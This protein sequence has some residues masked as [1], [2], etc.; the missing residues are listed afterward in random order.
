MMPARTKMPGLFPSGAVVLSIDTE[1]IWGYF[2]VLTEGGFRERFPG[3]VEAQERLLTRLQMAGVSATWFVV[4]AM[5]L[6]ECDG[7][8]DPRLTGLPPHWTSRIPRGHENSAG[9]WYRPSFVRRLR[10]ACPLQE[11]G[12]HGGLTHLIWTDLLVTR[13][14]AKRE[15][16]EGIR[17]LGD[18]GVQ[19]LTF[20]F[21]RIQEAHQT[22]L[23]EHGLRSYRGCIPSL[24]WKLGRGLPGAFLRALDE[25]RLATPPLVWPQ[26]MLPGLWNIPASLFLYRIA[27]LR[28]RLLGLRSRLERFSR[29]L[30]A[31]VRYGAIIHF[32]LHPENLT[33]SPHGF[34]LLDD[35]LERLIRAR[36]TDGIEVLTMTDVVTRMERNQLCS[37]RKVIPATI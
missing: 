14:S 8:R 5:A 31:A 29:G 27:P 22:L 35:I 37:T 9:L 16:V 4:G 30:E 10:D 11:I 19:P 36:Q 6:G 23:P 3:A 17:A 13:E 18:M 33:E 26:E 28:T 20:S 2:D 7:A 12:L 15:L 24:A 34:A 21:P 32:S 25:W 1:Q